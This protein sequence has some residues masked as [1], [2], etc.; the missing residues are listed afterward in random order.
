MPATT[1]ALQAGEPKRLE[2]AWGRRGENFTVRLDGNEIA[3]L[4]QKKEL[5]DGADFSLPD[6][7]TL[8]IQLRKFWGADEWEIL[9]NGQ[10][11]PGSATHPA[12][13]VRDAA[14]GVFLVS[15]FSLLSGVLN[16]A[17]GLEA[18]NFMGSGPRVI[19]VGVIGLVLGFLVLKRSRIALL[20]SLAV[21]A[22]D[23]VFVVIDLVQV[24]MMSNT[25]GYI[26]MIAL[27]IHA[28]LLATLIRGYDAINV[29]RPV[30]V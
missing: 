14:T 3:T 7:S 2:L 21:F 1:Y 11:I 26:P 16:L 22:V 20:A 6:G 13:R 25:S 4:L 23:T 9:R 10:P 5:S 17:T 29:K 28:W 19:I 30:S 15:G 12:T 24:P 27:L 8:H 18:F